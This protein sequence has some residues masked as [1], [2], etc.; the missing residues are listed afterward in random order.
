MNCEA[1]AESAAPAVEIEEM[2]GRKPR[3]ASK[4]TDVA[5]RLLAAFVTLIIH[6]R[7][8]KGNPLWTSRRVS[9]R[10]SARVPLMP[11]SSGSMQRSKVWKKPENPGSTRYTRMPKR[12]FHTQT[13][14]VLILSAAVFAACGVGGGDAESREGEKGRISLTVSVPSSAASVIAEIAKDFS[15]SHKGVKIA[16]NSGPSSVLASQVLSG[17]EVDVLLSAD[18]ASLSGVISAKKI[19]RPRIFAEN[20][21]TLIVSPRSP[22]VR[23]L[24]DLMDSEVVA[25]CAETVPCGVYAKRVLKNAGVYLKESQITRGTD[26]VS[27]LGAVRFGDADAAIVYKTDARAAGKSVLTRK[28]ADRFNLVA[29]YPSAVVLS[30]K[31]LN[32]SK[33]FQKY[34]ESTASKRVF[35][36]AGFST[37]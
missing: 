8:S 32:E 16:I 19:S 15:A 34:L 27:T 21:M 37:P 22:E 35:L 10:R 33:A 25:L 31:Y 14:G 1:A 26:A 12:R 18:L 20:Q 36:R 9:Y 4:R 6:P 7:F 23:S 29:R 11:V 17:A 24:R 2:L 13:V 3:D 30:S 28:I 5:M